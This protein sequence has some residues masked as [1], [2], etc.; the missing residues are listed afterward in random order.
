MYNKILFILG[1]YS[2]RHVRHVVL[3]E[4]DTLLDDSFNE[5]ITKFLSRFHVWM[6]FF[7]HI[8]LIPQIINISFTCS[9]HTYNVSQNWSK[10][11]T[12]SNFLEVH[13]T[14]Q[15]NIVELSLL[16]CLFTPLS[17]ASVQFVYIVFQIQL[18]PFE[19]LRSALDR[20]CEFGSSYNIYIF[21]DF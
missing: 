13:L 15:H 20:F 17:N 9:I 19:L 8:K 3:D 7:D 4:A 16:D 10:C 14:K 5:L 11:K 6:I 12:I 2:M 1:I 18:V 21:L